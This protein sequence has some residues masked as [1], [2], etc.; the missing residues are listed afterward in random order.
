METIESLR[1]NL[2]AYIRKKFYTRPNIIDMADDIVNQAF[3]EARKSPW[4]TGDKLNF[5]YMSLACLR[6]AYKAFH[7]NDRDNEI[8]LSFE[9][10]A[11]LIGEDDFIREIERAEDTAVILQSL[12]TLKQIERII[13]KERYYGSFTFRE[14]SQRHSINLNTVLSHHRR[15]LEKLRPIL[16][17]YYEYGET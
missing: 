13:I 17:S 6:R 15:A 16:S 11:P 1:E 5:G 10:A 4:F 9:L 12:A 3:L 2:V 14:I 7:Q 8:N